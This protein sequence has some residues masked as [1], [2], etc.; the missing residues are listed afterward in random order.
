MKPLLFLFAIIFSTSIIAQD[1]VI[2]PPYKR[3]PEYPPVK[4]LLADSSSFFTKDDLPKKKPVWLMMF[5]PQCTHCQHE[6]EELVKNIDEFKDIQVIMTT[7][8]PLDSMKAFSDKYKLSSYKNIIVGQDTHY[9]LFS[10]FQNRNLPFHAFYDKKKQLIKVFEGSVSI[11]AI[12]E[13]F[14]D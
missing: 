8:M 14:K 3:F 11:N 4:L 13:M 9:F 7:S 12:R 10:Y 6:T 5:N 2:D 1:K